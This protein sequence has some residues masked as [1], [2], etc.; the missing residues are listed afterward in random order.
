MN[1]KQIK[2]FILAGN[3]TGTLVNH[4]TGRRYTLRFRQ[5][6][7]LVSGK[8]NRRPVWIF[9]L[10]GPD[11]EHDYKYL[12]AIWPDNVDGW[13]LRLSGKSLWGWNDRV[14][15]AVDWFLGY[16]EAGRDLPDGVEFKHA[17]KCGRC[18]RTLTTPESIEMGLGP[19][20]AEKA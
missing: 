12:G 6:D 8:E 7:H 2:A 4:N 11:N 19:V 1:T 14:T 5:P 20:C 13:K 16:I 10:A 17:G 15:V 18:G 3:A 9:V